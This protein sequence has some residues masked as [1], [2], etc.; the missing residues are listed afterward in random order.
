MPDQP[1][2][3][4]WDTGARSYPAAPFH[5]G[6]AYPEYPFGEAVGPANPVYAGMRSLLQA[7]QVG[8]GVPGSPDWSPLGALVRP[9]D[10]VIIKPNFV[11]SE[12]PLGQPGID[13]AVAHGAVLRPLVDYA[14][15][16][17]RGR[18]RVII[19]DSPIK[20]VDFDRIVALSGIGEVL[21]FCRPRLPQGVSLELLD[22]RDAQV[23]RN[24]AGFMEEWAPLPGDPAGYT[25]VDLG[26]RSMFSEIAAHHRRLRS[27]AV[28]YEDV[29]ERF[30][31]PGHNVYSLPNTLLHADVVISVAKL[32]T[33]RKGGITL[34]LKNA[35][36]ITNEKRG[37]P[38]HR[39]GS[40]SEGGD[41]VP[42]GARLDAR[43]EDAFRD[44]ML[45]RPAGRVGLK[46]LGGPLRVL[47]ARVV[48]PAFR[49]LSPGRPATVEGDWYGNDT[50]WRMALDLN[51]ALFHAGRDGA[52]HELPQRRWLGIVD[53]VVAGEGEGPLYPDPLA[54]GV[55]VGGVHPLLTDIAATRLMGYD[56][57]RV[58]MLRE[59]VD[60]AWPL[61]PPLAPE[62][63][64]IVSNRPE[65]QALMTGEDLPFRFTPTA[66]WRGHIE[67][68]PRASRAISRTGDRGAPD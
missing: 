67:L 3:A 63:M 21:A 44:F 42:D 43:I 30:H 33:H 2:V 53:G 1:H 25:K 5:P 17:L 38:H 12:H 55:L 59:G 51:Y 22:F 6:E 27:T 29:M 37:L 24:R 50:V 45:S 15:L 61:R 18:G 23:R 40:P 4:I 7:L 41:A 35:V 64:V 26:A 56:W 62:D 58:P 65:W 66:G 19:A 20:E 57:R 47:A 16:A 13:A 14:V 52:L 34:T 28:Y 39:V 36:G 10:T 68:Q 32:K 31:S 48:K 46:L 11:V 54:C 60:R 49:R 9:G 8:A